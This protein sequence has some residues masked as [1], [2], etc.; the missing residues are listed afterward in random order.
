MS[1][2]VTATMTEP[3]SR[4][5]KDTGTINRWDVRLRSDDT[6]ENGW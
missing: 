3:L 2:E 4:W 1:Q 6:Y 5:M